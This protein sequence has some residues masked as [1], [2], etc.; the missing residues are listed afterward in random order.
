M[1][2]VQRVA[3]ESLSAVRETIGGYRQ[4]SLATELAGAR[5]ALAA[6][7]IEGRVEPGAGRRFRRRPTR[8]SAGRFARA[9]RTSSGTATPGWPRSSSGRR[10][11]RRRS[12]SATTGASTTGGGRFATGGAAVE[13]GPATRRRTTPWHRARPARA[14]PVFA[15]GWP[16]SAAS[17]RLAGCPM[18]GSGFASRSRSDD[19]AARCRGPGARPRRDRGPARAGARPGGRRGGRP[20]RRGPAAGARDAPG[21]RSPGHR[22]ARP[23]RPVGGG[24]AADRRCRRAGSSSSRR[25]AAPAISAGRW[26]RARR[27]SY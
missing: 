15:T 8:S 20:R 3:R 18:V 24:P 10:P 22:D 16:G 9:S 4:S 26:R 25:S 2:D 21:C 17:S 5:S 6:A 11:T 23:R 14:S 7:G 12:R 27:A 13:D 19:P 1:D